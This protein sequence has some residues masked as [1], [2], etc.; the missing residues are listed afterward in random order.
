MH[1]TH[2]PRCKTRRKISDIATTLHN[3]D[4]YSLRQN[5]MLPERSSHPILLGQVNYTGWWREFRLDAAAE[6]YL[7]LYTGK[8]NLLPVPTRPKKPD[9]TRAHKKK[10]TPWEALRKINPDHSKEHIFGSRVY[11]SIPPEYRRKTLL[12]ARA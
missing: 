7:D 5:W 11:V 9:T 6:G 3:P 4:V 10:T 12:Q 2:R 8:E 1:K